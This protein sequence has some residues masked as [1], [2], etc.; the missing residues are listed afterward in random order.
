ITNVSMLRKLSSGDQVQSTNLWQQQLAAVLKAAEEIRFAGTP[1]LWINLSGDVTNSESFKGWCRLTCRATLTPWGYFEGVSLS[2]GI[3]PDASERQSLALINATLR[4]AQME[5]GTLRDLMINFE[6]SYPHTNSAWF[7]SNWKIS[8]REVESRDV[9]CSNL[10]VQL[11]SDQADDSGTNFFSQVSLS[12]GHSR[13]PYAIRAE[14]AGL[15]IGVSHTYPLPILRR[16]LQSK[17]PGAT[18]SAGS[19][20]GMELIPS[21]NW[22]GDWSLVLDGISGQAGKAGSLS[23]TGAVSHAPGTEEANHEVWGWWSHLKNFQANWSGT[24]SNY[25]SD[26]LSIDIV[27]GSGEW[28]APLLTVNRLD[29]QL[30]GGTLSATGSL[31][32]PS[33]QLELKSHAHFDLHQAGDVMDKTVRNWLDQFK[34]EQPPEIEV[35]MGMRFPEWENPRPNWREEVMPT[36]TLAGSLTIT[37]GTFYKIPASISATEFSLTNFLWMVPRL[38]ISRPEGNLIVSYEGDLKT[39]RFDWKID[40]SIDITALSPLIKNKEGKIA[41]Q[42]A[43]FSVPPKIVASIHGRWDDES[44]LAATGTVIATNFVYHDA[45]FDSTSLNFSYSNRFITFTDLSAT[46]PGEMAT[47]PWAMIDLRRG[48]MYVTNGFSTMD[49]YMATRLMGPITARAIRPYQFDRPPTVQV[50]GRIPLIDEDDADMVFKIKGGSFHWW[51]LNLTSL[52]GELYWKSNVVAISNSV[53][54][55]YEGEAQWT[56]KFLFKADDSADLAFRAVIANSNLAPLV[57]DLFGTTNRLEGR[58]HGNLVITSGNTEDQSSWEGF[59]EAQLREGFLWDMPLFGVLNP[60]LSSLAPNLARNAVT[61][62]NASYTISGG[63]IY[64]QDLELRAPAFRMKYNGFVDFDGNV[65]ARME[66]QML[67]DT[68]LV[69]KAF[70]VALWP[71][72]KVLETRVTG[73]LSEPKSEPIYIPKIVLF[74]LRPIQTLKELF[75]QKTNDPASLLE[76]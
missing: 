56:G 8:A 42:R 52:Q 19:P 16:F 3:F 44:S 23:L 5:D 38:V 49:P 46:R 17:M 39:S 61:A 50:N 27:R 59:G 22:R 70:S 20:T 68:W 55:F 67:R 7:S 43:E 2:S 51:K 1:D 40:S 72:A 65:D 71:L 31:D 10:V 13:F 9:S 73:K 4:H 18:N 34:W 69:G 12:A 76:K 6:S 32:I 74:P 26:K 29:A 64:T 75:P 57:K 15:Q 11:M 24:I 30:Y 62:G 60:M 54:G 48:V 45:N 58:L 41:L 33:R 25:N 53:A 63:K 36:F 37:N 21:Q 66:A 35:A 14:Q 47:A 28:K